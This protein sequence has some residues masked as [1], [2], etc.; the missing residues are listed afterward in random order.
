MIRVLIADDH[1]LFREMLSLTLTRSGKLEVVG[2]A[3]CG[4]DALADA[5]K[6]RPDVVL[7]DYKMPGV[8]D[9]QATIDAIRTK[10]D[11]S[12]VVLSGYSGTEIAEKAARGGARGYILKT[13]PSRNVLEA[14][15]AVAGGEIW[16]DRDLGRRA[17]ESFRRLE[18]IDPGAIDP[19]DSLNRRELRVLRLLARGDTNQQI[20]F[21]LHLGEVDVKALV[22]GIL[23]KLG[24]DDRKAAARVYIAAR[25]PGS[26]QA[27]SL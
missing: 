22:I 21:Q 23:A 16:V 25:A 8:I 10:S 14:V 13:T 1:S 5:E 18:V 26:P 15:L 11:A 19:I 6:Y 12:V 9:F 20:A 7:L 3:A 27:V 4:S 2:E 17:L 24:V